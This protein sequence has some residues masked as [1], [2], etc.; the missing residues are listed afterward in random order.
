MQNF[1]NL[2]SPPKKFQNF[3][4]FAPVPTW[5]TAAVAVGT[6]AKLAAL[7]RMLAL[8]RKVSGILIY[9]V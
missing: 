8:S 3:F 2:K 4:S 5:R 1:G 7:N 6:V 9:N